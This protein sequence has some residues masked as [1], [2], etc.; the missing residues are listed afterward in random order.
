MLRELRNTKQIE[1]EPRRRW[2]FSHELDL[3]VWFD[4]NGM[5]C[6]FQLAYDKY[7]G[8][9]SISWNPERGFRHFVVDDGEPRVGCNDTPFLYA[10]GPFQ[11]DRVLRQFVALSAEL[12]ADISRFVIHKL[13]EFE[14]PR[15]P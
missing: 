6:A 10:N 1:G 12:P 15:P 4:R 9:H 2:F 5:P 3:V 13:V 14:G 11:L 8:E 7:R